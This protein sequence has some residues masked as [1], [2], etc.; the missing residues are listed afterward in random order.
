MVSCRSVVPSELTCAAS[1]SNSPRRIQPAWTLLIGPPHR[2]SAEDRVVGLLYLT[3]THRAGA[4]KA[5]GGE[6][7]FPDARPIARGASARRRRRCRWRYRLLRVAQKGRRLTSS[8][9]SSAH[10]ITSVPPGRV[11]WSGRLPC[12]RAKP[13]REQPDLVNLN[14]RLREMQKQSPKEFIFLIMRRG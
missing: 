2:S 7:I 9:Q 6:K 10:W 12:R 1:C 11:A 3:T 14:D 4:M 8:A 13:V 5:E